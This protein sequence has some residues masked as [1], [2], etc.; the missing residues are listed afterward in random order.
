MVV[1]SDG[2]NAIVDVHWLAPDT[3]YDPEMPAEHSPS[4]YKTGN[5]DETKNAFHYRFYITSFFFVMGSLNFLI[6][7]HMYLGFL[8]THVG[9]SLKIYYIL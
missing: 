4:F 2:R 3:F 7:N 5:P 9:P 1:V 8:A 6:R